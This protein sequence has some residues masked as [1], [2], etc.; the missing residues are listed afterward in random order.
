MVELNYNRF[1]PAAGAVFR[2]VFK[3]ETHQQPGL[4]QLQMSYKSVRGVFP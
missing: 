1:V 3:K 4:S 2:V